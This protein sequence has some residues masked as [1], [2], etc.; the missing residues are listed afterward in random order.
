[1]NLHEGAS[2]FEVVVKLLLSFK[3]VQT[4]LTEAG[5]WACSLEV[6][7]KSEDVEWLCFLINLGLWIFR[8][9]AVDLSEFFQHN[10]GLSSTSLLKLK[11]CIFIFALF[12][13]ALASFLFL[14]FCLA[15]LTYNLA[16][17]LAAHLLHGNLVTRYAPDH[18]LIS[19]ENILAFELFL[20][21]WKEIQ[22]LLPH[23][24]CL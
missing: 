2:N 17:A 5:H 22:L 24:L 18:F 9:A 3:L 8:T 6:F 23:D 10:L 19:F 12:G 1:V 4:E 11:R 16:A 15:R 20:V 13:W 21:V 14:D 7:V